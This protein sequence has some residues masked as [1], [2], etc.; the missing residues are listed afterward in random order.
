MWKRR[1]AITQAPP[2][3]VW[4]QFNESVLKGDQLERHRAVV[5][6]L[7][8]YFRNHPVRDIEQI[9]GISRTD[10][11][12]LAKKCLL[13]ASDGRIL[14]FRALEPYV[15]FR[16]NI[17]RAEL[18]P[19]R[20]QQQGG[21]SGALGL[22]LERFP[23]TE[24]TMVKLITKEAEAQEVM[25][26]KLRPKDLHRLFI[27]FVNA[28]GLTDEE[29]PKN[30]SYRGVRTIERFMKE[31]LDRNFGRTATTR[32]DKDAKAHISVG[33]GHESFLVFDEPYD[34]V[35][36]DAYS[37]EA[38][39]SVAVATPEGTEVELLLERLSLIAAV[40]RFSSAVLAYMVVYRSEVTADDVLRVIRDA[41]TGRWQPR[42]LTIPNLSYPER[43][44]LPS[45]VIPSAHGAVWTATLL[46]G[47]LAHLANAI[48]DRARKA[49]GFFLNW[50]AVGHFERRP[51]VERFFNQISKDLF[52]RLP[53]TTGSNPQKGRAKDAERKA[54]RYRIRAAE[55][56]QLLDICI[57]QHNGVPSE[58]NS[59]LSPLE[60]LRFFLEGADRAFLV[61][62]LPGTMQEV[63]KTFACREEVTV[64]GGQHTGRRPYIQLDKAKYTSPVLA[65]AGHLVG[66]KIIVDIFDEDDFRQIR[67]YLKSGAELGILKVQGRW[68]LTKHSRRTRR[69]I[70]ALANRR[71]IVLSEYDDPVHKYLQY[72][73]TPEKGKTPS[74]RQATELTRI[75]KE[76]GIEPRLCPPKPAPKLENNAAHPSAPPAGNAAPPTQ[77]TT[78]NCPPPH[79]ILDSD[80]NFFRKVKNRR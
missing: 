56:E 14:G 43:G 57:A 32:G 49:L 1:Q 41:A 40:E 48:H 65:N 2:V 29:W 28:A 47:A 62:K 38:H 55:V 80:G 70:N 7:T 31:V 9:T 52:K 50:G 39:M 37:I 21:Q 13:T 63:T 17:R 33:T 71:I 18:Q 42:P 61:R 4:P 11:P 68:A 12:R 24:A 59:Y 44:G 79:S 15:R 51:N 58:G 78:Q 10:L 76:A 3:E 36:I 64:R 20:P 34:A 77:P 75:A 60:S 27:N 66:Q 26:H 6:A 46:D 45:G 19:K 5:Q 25:E 16:P 23:E 22:F 74:P 67:A 73:S 8:L 72:L 54:L 53:S 35:E 69:A 30:T